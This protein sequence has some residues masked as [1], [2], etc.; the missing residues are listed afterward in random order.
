[1]EAAQSA[2]SGSQYLRAD[3]WIRYATEVRLAAAAP[4]PAPVAEERLTLHD[5]EAGVCDTH[6]A[7]DDRFTFRVRDKRIGGWWVHTHDG[8]AC[9]LD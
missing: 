5:V 1:M 4:G 3:V 2:M 7:F 8:S 6:P 9:D